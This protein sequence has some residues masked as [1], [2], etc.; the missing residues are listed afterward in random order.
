MMSVTSHASPS[1]LPSMADPPPPPLL[2]PLLQ[3]VLADNRGMA[4]VDAAGHTD[5]LQASHAQALA[6]LLRDAV[7]KRDWSRAAGACVRLSNCRRQPLT[8]AGAALA[9]V[10]LVVGPP[11]LGDP[12]TLF[13]SSDA[14]VELLQLVRLQ[15]SPPGRTARVVTPCVS[16][17]RR[18]APSTAPSSRPSWRPRSGVALASAL[19]YAATR[20]WRRKRGASG[21]QRWLSEG[22]TW[23]APPWSPA[24]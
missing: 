14:P 15:S 9:S 11:L 24:G 8:P 20:P 4:R 5:R 13:K 19:G 10:G 17:R 22:A 3:R 23:T 16:R 12:R 6:H 7:L 2:G 1:H 18:C 21:R